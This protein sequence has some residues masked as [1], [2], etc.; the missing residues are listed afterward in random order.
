MS[1]RFRSVLAVLALL[2]T[3]CGGGESPAAP[4]N[5]APSATA[6]A[7]MSCPSPVLQVSADGLPTPVIFDYPTVGGTGVNKSS[8]APASGTEFGIGTSQVTCVADQEELASTCSFSVSVNPPELSCPAPSPRQ[9]LDGLPVEVSWDLPS[10]PN[11]PA[12]VVSCSPVSGT[13][14]PIGQ[15]TVTCTADWP[16]V[17]T[18]AD[19]PPPA[20]SCEF[21][22]AIQAPD[23]VLGA[24]KFLAFGDSITAGYVGEGFLSTR[25]S[26]LDLSTLL[27]ADSRQRLP[28]VGRAVQP[29]NS[30]PTQL[31]NLLRTGYP[32]QSITV[33]N[34]G[35]SGERAAEGISRL[36]PAL[37]AFQPDVLLLLEG[38]NDLNLALVLHPSDD[39]NPIDV[40]TFADYLRGMVLDA[41]ARGVEVLLATLTP[42]SDARESVSPGVQAAI[43]AL[44]AEIRSMAPSLGNGGIVDLHAALD[45]IS[46]IIGADGLHPTSAGYRRMAEIFYS[47]IVSR[48]DNTPR[49]AALRRQQ[50][51]FR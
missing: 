9:S 40:G 23:P 27:R 1:D 7:L 11:T 24:P 25:G 38:I 41:E 13:A 28:R 33:S 22:I 37:D 21:V 35:L 43:A 36:K 46:G 29:H 20:D 14:F 26:Q 39:P 30:Y 10:L 42:V 51:R 18:V 5:P 3:S 45:G 49:G 17:P 16:N 8:C 4:T 6:A 2:L 50:L 47:Q 31:L 34:Q 48:Y 15:S 12:E 19:E 32:T 44:N